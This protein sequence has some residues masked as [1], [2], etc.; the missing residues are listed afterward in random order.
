MPEALLHNICNLVDS[1]I[2]LGN[3]LK[4]KDVT[5]KVGIGED[6]P[7]KIIYME[8]AQ[9]YWVI[10]ESYHTIKKSLSE[11]G[12][13]DFNWLRVFKNVCIGGSLG[14]VAGLS[15]DHINLYPIAAGAIVLGGITIYDETTNSEID[16]NNMYKGA[17]IGFLVGGLIEIFGEKYS[18]LGFVGGATIG[19]AVDLYKSKP[20]RMKTMTEWGK[21]LYANDEIFIMARKE[22][23]YE[24]SS[25]I[26]N[27]KS[28]SQ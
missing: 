28:L 5:E 19:L 6:D 16:F 11:K 26:K 15:N 8:F 17:G 12:K 7:L 20:K 4:I 24:T 21:A 10:S 2:M 27:Q 23:I 13:L 22:L 3:Y 14:V 1:E 18:K 9:Q 25:L